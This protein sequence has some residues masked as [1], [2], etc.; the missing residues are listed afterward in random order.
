M[1]PVDLD[2]AVRKAHRPVH[3][4]C[5]DEGDESAVEEIEI[6]GIGPQRRPV[7]GRGGLVVAEAGGQAA[8]QE[9]AGHGHRHRRQALADRPLLGRGRVRDCSAEGE[10]ADQGDGSQ[11]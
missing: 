10:R 5:R 8:R 6:A 1:V 7:E 3:L 9:A 4:A 2:E 11:Q